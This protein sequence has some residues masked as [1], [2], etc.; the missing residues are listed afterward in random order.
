MFCKEC[1]A[2][3]N[4][5]YDY[6]QYCGASVNEPSPAAMPNNEQK[7]TS[8]KEN[9]SAEKQVS[10]QVNG[11]RNDA[12]ISWNVGLGVWIFLLL[13]G[14]FS[15]QVW[16]VL[17]SA[18]LIGGTLSERRKII[19]KG[20]EPDGQSPKDSEHTSEAE[21]PDQE[22]AADTKQ[23][24]ITMNLSGVTYVHDGSDPQ[25]EI[26]K[27]HKADRVFLV[28][29]PGNQYDDTAIKVV[30]SDGRY[31]GWYPKDGEGNE[32]IFS[33][34]MASEELYAEVVNTGYVLEHDTWWC[35][36]SVRM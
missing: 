7:P 18:F 26:S 16:L 29:D 35:K 9:Q 24:L 8:P 19:E 23:R 6:C 30:N 15:K 20:L 28:P 34:L 25:R 5:L 14:A 1:G 2:E 27:L 3:L 21:H 22:S 32:E 13:L 4:P 10:G 17:V 33:R 11:K 12:L 36:I 31:I